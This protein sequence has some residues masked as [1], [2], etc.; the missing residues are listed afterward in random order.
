[1]PGS[2]FPKKD[3]YGKKPKSTH[4]ST[5]PVSPVELKG[6]DLA[7]TTSDHTRHTTWPGTPPRVVFRLR[8]AARPG[9]GSQ[10]RP[11]GG[12]REYLGGYESYK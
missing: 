6:S 2:G 12:E 4:E 11:G 8:L 1:M 7:K 3:L 9:R 5:F 10:A